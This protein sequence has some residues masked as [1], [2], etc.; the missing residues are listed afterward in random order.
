MYDA[1]SRRLAWPC[2]VYRAAT[3]HMRVAGRTRACGRCNWQCAGDDKP[4]TS[5]DCRNH[6]LP[7]CCVGWANWW[8]VVFGLHCQQWKHCQRAQPHTTIS[9]DDHLFGGT[10]GYGHQPALFPRRVSSQRCRPSLPPRSE[11]CLTPMRECFTRERALAC[12]KYIQRCLCQK[13]SQ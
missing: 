11:T 9:V 7:L 10:T 6:V 5:H 1:I 4:R 13:A 8:S 2:C 3:P 12:A